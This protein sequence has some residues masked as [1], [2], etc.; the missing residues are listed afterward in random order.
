MKNISNCRFDWFL[1]MVELILNGKRFVAIGS[2]SSNNVAYSNDGKIWTRLDADFLIPI[3]QM[4]FRG[5]EISGWLDK[6][7]TFTIILQLID[8]TGI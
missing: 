1:M 5:L 3:I 4:L 2:L 8:K 6:K 7:I